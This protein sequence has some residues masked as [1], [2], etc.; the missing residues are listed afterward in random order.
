MAGRD[1]SSLSRWTGDAFGSVG[2][3]WSLEENPG[4]D[5]ARRSSYDFGWGSAQKRIWPKSTLTGAKV[6]TR[7]HR[8]ITKC[9]QIELVKSFA[10]VLCTDCI[11]SDTIEQSHCH[12]LLPCPSNE[13][14]SLRKL[15]QLRLVIVHPPRTRPKG[16]SIEE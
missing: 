9:A 2:C 4:P 11:T 8:T 16:Q 7:A 14:S 1:V 12:K 10:K 5:V 6:R 13:L 3:E 15:F